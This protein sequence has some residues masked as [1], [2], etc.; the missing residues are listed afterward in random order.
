MNMRARGKTLFLLLCLVM[1]G[2]SCSNASKQAKKLANAP[3][4]L[5]EVTGEVRLQRLWSRKLGATQDKY[6]LLRMAQF[7]SALYV[8]NIH[9][10]VFA[11]DNEKGRLLW[12]HHIKEI[13]AQKTRLSGAVGLYSDLLLLGDERG[14]LF[15]ISRNTGEQKWMIKLSAPII[16]PASGAK[17]VVVA[18]TADGKIHARSAVD[19]RELWTY[20]SVLP[21]LTLRG[22]SAP[23]VIS[24]AVLVGLDDGYVVAIGL[25]NGSEL[26]RYRLARPTGDSVIERL[27]D[28]D[29][30]LVLNGDLLHAVSYQGSIGAVTWQN[31][32]SVWE[33]DASSYLTP[34][35]GLGHVYIVDED[36]HV[37]AYEERRGQLRWKQEQLANRSLG[38]PS[39]ISSFVV[40]VDKFGYTHLLGQ[41]DGRLVARV[42]HNKTGA[43]APIITDENIFY[44]LGNRGRLS[45]YRIGAP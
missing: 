1:L 34:A 13:R 44:I 3:K 5:Q 30:D 7:G 10:H 12:R 19:G 4:P 22:Y 33:E 38:P 27:V 23:L 24:D 39:T 42:R 29:G 43:R 16:V 20:S 15:A 2:V 21:V 17:N 18:R 11:I 8:A 26:W 41:L 40:V 45:A 25:D 37:V 9:G 36:S 14:R 35:T 31:G 6:S 28:I 32:Q